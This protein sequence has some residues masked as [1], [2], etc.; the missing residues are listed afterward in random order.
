M[1]LLRK[2]RS[3]CLSKVSR[4]NSK[5]LFSICFPHCVDL[6]CWYLCTFS[7][8][9]FVSLALSL[10]NILT[11]LICSEFQ[12]SRYQRCRISL[13]VDKQQ[14]HGR[15][16]V[17]VC[18]IVETSLATGI[19]QRYDVSAGTQF[20]CFVKQSST[21]NNYFSHFEKDIW[22]LSRAFL[23][24]FHFILTCRTLW[25]QSDGVHKPYPCWS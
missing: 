1:V 14:T 23:Q 18:K 6:W 10:A 17:D 7:P 21:P 2:A 13:T 3:Y 25:L 22:K 15:K 11:A 8:S 16:T 19:S 4:L 9:I 5:N 20:Y 12:V 24:H